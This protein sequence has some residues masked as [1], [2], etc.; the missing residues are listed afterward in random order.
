MA[1]I[2]RYIASEYPSGLIATYNT[3][4]DAVN[5]VPN[6]RTQSEIIEVEADNNTSETIIGFGYNTKSYSEH[7]LVIRGKE[8]QDISLSRPDANPMIEFV[9]SSGVIDHGNILV[10][11]FTILGDST[12]TRA[13]RT[14]GRDNAGTAIYVKD[15]TFKNLRGIFTN[16]NRLEVSRYNNI[17]YENCNFTVN[18]GSLIVGFG[19]STVLTNGTLTLKNSHFICN[20]SS[21]RLLSF[22]NVLSDK[23]EVIDCNL[24]S[25]QT[26]LY[27]TFCQELLVERSQINSIGTAI[28]LVGHSSLVATKLKVINSII[29]TA[30]YVCAASTNMGYAEFYYN[31]IAWYGSVAHSAIFVSNINQ[32]FKAKGNILTT[33]NGT[34]IL[35]KNFIKLTWASTVNIENNYN[36]YYRH[37][38]TNFTLLEVTDS[39]GTIS[40]YVNLSDLYNIS[41][42]LNSIE[43]VPLFKDDTYQASDWF[44]LQ[45]DSGAIN[46][47]PD[48]Q[49]DE[50]DYRGYYRQDFHTDAGAWDH[51]ADSLEKPANDDFNDAPIYRQSD[52]KEYGSLQAAMNDNKALEKDEVI[53]I[54][55]PLDLTN[56][57]W[58][59][60]WFSNSFN[61]GYTLTIRRSEELKNSDTLVEVRLNAGTCLSLENCYNLIFEGLHFNGTA[62]N[63]VTM[64]VRLG[65]AAPGNITFINCHFTGGKNGVY[66]YT[67]NVVQFI[68]C[69]AYNNTEYQLYL[70]GGDHVL[71][72]NCTLYFGEAIPSLAYDVRSL[73]SIR[74]IKN[75]KIKDCIFDGFLSSSNKFSGGDIAI[76][77]RCIFKNYGSIPIWY[78]NSSIPSMKEV[79]ID[80]CIFE[81]N[82]QAGDNSSQV[83]RFDD[84]VKVKLYN[85]TIKH[86][87]KGT[88]SSVIILRGNSKN[89]Y[90]E[91]VECFNNYFEITDD[92]TGTQVRYIIAAELAAYTQGVNFKTGANSYNFNKESTLLRIS[93]V[94][95]ERGNYDPDKIVITLADAAALGLEINSFEI[96]TPELGTFTSLVDENNI[97]LVETNLINAANT[98][99]RYSY[100]T[101][102]KKQPQSTWDIGA[103]SLSAIDIPSGVPTITFKGEKDILSISELYENYPV[104]FP[105]GEYLPLISNISKFPSKVLWEI[106]EVG[107]TT[108]ITFIEN[109]VGATNFKVSK[110]YQNPSGSPYSDVDQ[111]TTLLNSLT[112]SVPSSFKIEGS[113]NNDGTYKKLNQWIVSPDEEPSYVMVSLEGTLDASDISGMLS[114]ESYLY[115]GIGE[116]A[117]IIPT[118][119]YADY[120]LKITAINDSGSTVLYQEPF[121]HTLGEIPKADFKLSEY[122]LFLGDTVDVLSISKNAVFHSWEIQKPSSSIIQESENIID[123]ELDE[124]GTYVTKLTVVNQDGFVREIVK[125]MTIVVNPIPT[126]P[127]I[128]MEINPV[129][130]Q[131]QSLKLTSKSRFTREDTTF[132]WNIINDKTGII[133]HTLT[134]ETIDVQ[135]DS[136]I[137]GFGFYDVELEVHQGGYYTS[138]LEKRGLTVLPKIT[139]K[140]Q[141]IIECN[142]N[143]THQIIDGVTPINGIYN[144]PI[145][146]GDVIKLRGGA[147]RLNLDNLKGTAENPIIVIPDNP[148]GVF[149]C[150]FA[151][152]VGLEIKG[153]EHVIIAGLPNN[154]ENKYGFKIY[155]NPDPALYAG[156]PGNTCVKVL[157]FSNYI[158]LIGLELH[159]AKFAGISSKTDPDSKKPETWRNPPVSSGETDFRMMGSVISHCYVHDTHGEGCYLG[160]FTETQIG[161]AHVDSGFEGHPYFAHAMGD[162]LIFRNVWENNGFDAIQLGNHYLGMSEIHHNTIIN[163]GYLGIFGQASAMS[164]NFAACKIYNNKIDNMLNAALGAPGGM[165]FY[166]NVMYDGTLYYH[167]NVTQQ[168]DFSTGNPTHSGQ[169]Y[170]YSITPLNIYNNIIYGRGDIMVINCKTGQSELPPTTLFNN[171]CL[172]RPHMWK[173]AY[174]PTVPDRDQNVVNVMNTYKTFNISTGFNSFFSNNV[175]EKY[176][177]SVLATLK[178]LNLEGIEP[179]V[180]SSSP[181]LQGGILP[182]SINATFSNRDI[183]GLYPSS[184]NRQVGAYTWLPITGESIVP[185]DYQSPTAHTIGVSFI[186]PNG[187]HIIGSITSDG[188]KP[189]IERGFLISTN[190]NPTVE[191]GIKVTT[192]PGVGG[193]FINKFNLNHGI[194][195]Y[196]R[197]FATNEIGVG[198]GVVLSVVIPYVDTVNPLDLQIS[199][200]IFKTKGIS[201][202]PQNVGI[203]TL[204]LVGETLK[205]PAFEPVLVTNFNEFRA[206]F[207]LTSP[208]KDGNGNPKYEL[209]YVAKSYLQE[210]NQLFVT[211]ILG[212]T[213]YKPF[214]TFG[215]KT[216]G[217]II[218]GEVSGTTFSSISPGDSSFSGT[219]LYG[220]ELLSK[221]TVDGDTF[222][223]YLESNFNGLTSGNTGTW[224]TIGYVPEDEL[225][226]SG[227]QSVSPINGEYLTKKTNKNWYNTFYS[228]STPG[229]DETINAV[230]SY[231]FVYDGSQDL[232]E[233]TEFVFEAS[234]NDDYHNV[235]VAALSPRGSYSGQTLNLEVTS[236]NG[237]TL[238]NTDSIVSNP[239]SEFTLNVTGL[240]SG[241]VSFNCSLSS[242][243][244][245]FISKV[246]G[247]EVFNKPKSQYPLYVREC[248]PNLISKAFQQGKIRGISPT[249]V[250]NLESDNF[251]T[252][253]LSTVSPYVVSE[254]RGNAVFDLFRFV[255]ISDGEESNYQVKI[256]VLNIDLETKEFDIAIRDFN[257]T[258]DNIEVVETYP[259]CS[260]NPDSPGFIGK[261][262]GTSDGEYELRSKYVMLE[263]ADNY[264][265][266]AVPCGFRGYES[267]SSFGGS[268]L[269]Q[270]M[271]KTSYDTAGDIIGYETDGTPIQSA[272]DRNRKVCLGMSSH[273]GYDKDLLKFKGKEAIGLSYGFHL[274]SNASSIGGFMT[275]PYNLEGIDKGLLSPVS[276]RKFVFALYGGFDGWDIYRE[277]RTF[278]DSYVLGKNTYTSGNTDN[279]GVF[280][281]NVGNS[282]Y[283]AY[284]KGIETF[285]NPESV[286]I[287]VFATPGINFSDH[288]SLTVQ[289]ID[290]IENKRGDSLYIIS[291]PN[292]STASEII[293]DLDS[294]G[295]DTNYSATYWPWIQ[296]R[297]NDNSTQLYI[298]PTGEV[299]RN[300]ALTDNVSYPWFAVAGYDRGLVNSIKTYKKLTP[301]EQ[302]DLYKNRINPIVTF[303]DVGDV[304]FGNK[305]LQV[306]ESSLNRINVRRLLLR[307]RKLISSVASTLLFNQNNED[308][309]SEFIRLVNPILEVMRKERGLSQFNVSVSNDP[310]DINS[311]TLRGKIYVKPTN[312]LEVIDISFVLTPTGASFEDI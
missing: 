190:I 116:N 278:G 158:Q 248:Y 308:I 56:N 19:S 61:Y 290:M 10:E 126:T 168:W 303:S 44:N 1:V 174:N 204:G 143:V 18:S 66:M 211:R 241:P 161:V 212:L 68:N 125:P 40:S 120:E 155:I 15:I 283:Y 122:E 45:D 171:V 123:L 298:P 160:Y 148:N 5:A 89:S 101:N 64:T 37:T 2:K 79:L 206:L 140:T 183:Q 81:N 181:L 39:S 227:T 52:L 114:W 22:A 109:L 51:D 235:V 195:Y 196:V 149:E 261:K 115:K 255:T 268:F 302:D 245:R 277:T 77:E 117:G 182:T 193:Y 152:W 247:T 173:N 118:N 228:Q 238:S 184:E 286:N 90:T 214:N 244:S 46:L 203:T 253:W 194:T 179:Y 205:G 151:S 250:Y 49:L 307:A 36:L 234:L 74:S 27:I 7:L 84:T 232:F 107:T 169:L 75:Y 233:V 154:G 16:A 93:R 219:T 200:A 86:T 103:N 199:P 137:T 170:D 189:I 167:G 275:T 80:S 83:M 191:N 38:G 21:T 218:V 97:P 78:V 256:M 258:D 25:A 3:L 124:L 177:P 63:R 136:I 301:K 310:E 147:Q 296:V 249:I 142:P 312:S 95:R 100:Y 150:I 106:Q 291:T 159:S 8:G 144:Q 26:C 9:I 14:A 215:L 213:G 178:F 98:S 112:L 164:I 92:V 105:K 65:P 108:P 20:D 12:G 157:G 257:D 210:S 197:S 222:E 226:T 129:I 127:L 53:I 251:M 48:P 186:S 202:D 236:Q 55:Q 175:I 294:V 188:G 69:H 221:T 246:I 145:V 185:E 223:S 243:S 162:T 134:G 73:F 156:M 166:N 229:D 273:I 146:A 289:S 102:N 131:D 29:N 31:T 274:S 198:Y 266:D 54:T 42:E 281:K 209:P 225:P 72:D 280:S 4:Q 128:K 242:S 76:I 220:P 259:K 11:N 306:R 165:E 293:N 180:A 216:L 32:F 30:S 138:K 132:K 224:F 239:L 85:N 208:L 231:L 192:L 119:Q 35:L 300:I 62:E 34:G 270:I 287:N 110:T 113:V 284:L 217:G 17:I 297:D 265:I 292:R 267:N 295:L 304:L 111:L 121:M 282:D 67:G 139:G 262:I 28:H 141:H 71:V 172:I 135:W 240:T 271:Y 260:L 254:V 43:D 311:D 279:G 70:N 207:G 305:T 263:M 60:A 58:M 99:Y 269:G 285:S 130:F 41:Q 309:Q 88:S 153:C 299:V 133:V 24:E 59:G 230:Y 50:F 47:V 23:I 87:I 163:S 176:E 57:P 187:I 82:G 33:L 94:R 272:G 252:N 6:P 96:R 13:I 276:N 288:S 201:L 237:V 91:F 104:I 264:P